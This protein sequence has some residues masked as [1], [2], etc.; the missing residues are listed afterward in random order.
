MIKTAMIIEDCKLTLQM[1]KFLLMKLG[2]KTIFTV[3]NAS[4]FQQ[5][6][7]QY[8]IPDLIITDW[9][10]D[11]GFKGYDVISAMEKLGMP[12]A[13]VSSDDEKKL[14]NNKCHWFKKP[15]KQE[16]LL[17]WMQQVYD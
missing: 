7:S 13:V 8:V 16:Q 11:E 1:T 2:I 5:L 4:E 15:L 6:V 9:N 12:I 17:T 10:I 3:S 14:T